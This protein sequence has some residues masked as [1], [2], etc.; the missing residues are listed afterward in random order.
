MASS[1]PLNTKNA[2]DKEKYE[3]FLKNANKAKDLLS[4]I[5]D[6]ARQNAPQIAHVVSQPVASKSPSIADELTKL[7]KL[8]N[9]GIL[10]EEEF[11]AQK[12]KLLG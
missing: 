9:D 1:S 8:K 12:T 5:I 7:A 11:Q 10:T 6:D 2:T 4:I 3:E